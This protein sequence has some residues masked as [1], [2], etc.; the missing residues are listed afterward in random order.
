MKRSIEPINYERSD[1]SD[2][3]RRGIKSN[4]KTSLLSDCC[5]H[6][7]SFAVIRKRRFMFTISNRRNVGKSIRSNSKRKHACCILVGNSHNYISIVNE[8]SHS[9]SLSIKIVRAH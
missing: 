6:D 5:G 3:I 2:M 8:P 4:G 7:R 1:W 9:V